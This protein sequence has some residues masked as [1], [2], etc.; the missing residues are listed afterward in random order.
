MYRSLYP[1]ELA[2]EVSQTTLNGYSRSA[3]C[4][5][6]HFRLEGVVLTPLQHNTTQ[7][8]ET[9]IWSKPLAKFIIL[10]NQQ[11]SYNMQVKVQATFCLDEQNEY[12]QSKI[13]V[14][15]YSTNWS[16]KYH[17]QHWIGTVGLK[18]TL[19]DTIYWQG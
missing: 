13:Y 9:D 15:V 6:W 12:Q 19:C 18:K 1:Q 16:H 14:L 8:F 3:M 17:R 5:M 4:A 2:T 11:P 10:T 7:L